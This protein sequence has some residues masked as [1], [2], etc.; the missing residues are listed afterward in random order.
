MSILVTGIGVVSAVGIGATE[1]LSALQ[2]MQHGMTKP[3]LFSTS[4]NVPVAEIKLSNEE[5]K[6]RLNLDK[7]KH[8][9]RTALLGMLAAN[10]AF[11][12]ARLDNRLRVGLISSTSVGGMDS[13]EWFYPS[14]QSKINGGRLRHIIG[15]DCADATEHIADYLGH[16]QIATTISTACSSG[17]NAI[18]M[19]AE[20]IKANLLD[21]VIVGGT[22]ALCRFTMNGFNALMILDKAHCRPF[23]ATRSGLNLGEGAGYLVLQSEESLGNK[24]PYCR[25]TGYANTN[26]AYHQTA[27]SPNGEGPFLA[28]KKAL[29]MSG[30]A[31]E[32]VDYINIHGTGTENND[33]SESHALKRIFGENIP[34]F[35]SVKSLIGHTLGAAEGIEAVYSVMALTNNMLFGNLNFSTA[36]ADT[37][38][39][40]ITISTKKHINCVLSNA[41][42]FGGNDITLI[43]EKGNP[44]ALIETK[45]THNPVYITANSSIHPLTNEGFRL[46]ANE[47]DYKSVI[48]NV[49]LRRRMSRLIKMGVAAGMNCLNTG[50]VPT[51]DGI[52]TATGWGFL[53]DTE[54][55]LA[56]ITNM[57]EQ[58]LPPTAFIQSTFNTIGAQIALLIDNKNYNN[59]YV[60]RGISLESALLDAFLRLNNDAKNILVGGMDELTD[61]SYHLLQRI[62]GKRQVK[63]GEGAHFFLLSNK[64]L[65]DKP[66]AI[67]DIALLRR[68]QGQSDFECSIQ[69]FLNKNGLKGVTRCYNGTTY[70]LPDSI[71]FKTDCGEYPTSSGFALHQ[72]INHL[73]DH[74]QSEFIL[75]ANTF[76]NIS[77]GLMLIG[78]E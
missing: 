69:T 13:S 30:L 21:A 54:K 74:Q 45:R 36:I 44:Q 50:N 32:E 10:E 58:L 38:L 5:L 60:H 24:L 65:D 18:I 35:G 40:P 43:F 16:I 71:A 77:Y 78:R 39:S 42:G 33:L 68:P 66:I 34:P 37:G 46:S 9:T 14:Y 27:S 6:T 29:F 55:F 57:N 62:Y 2:E 51:L 15:H 61:T 76:D 19:G 4:L 52:I 67:Y 48:E 72:A 7:Q 64:P 26:D 20:L 47:P 59:T 17:G 23:D 49:T 63:M 25:L 8:Y 56:A 28:M 41:F 1:N 11:I 75:I 22:D 73:K 53:S 3:S 31:P 70:Y 12:D